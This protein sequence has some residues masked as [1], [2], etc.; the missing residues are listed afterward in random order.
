MTSVS[1]TIILPF[2]RYRKKE[3]YLT[4]RVV[5]ENVPQFVSMRTLVCFSFL[6]IF[7]FAVG[8]EF[9]TQLPNASRLTPGFDHVVDLNVS[10]D[11]ELRYVKDTAA[12]WIRV[13]VP[14]NTTCPSLYLI[15]TVDPVAGR[16]QNLTQNSPWSR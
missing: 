12:V 9:V 6:Y 3:A 14:R 11:L 8:Q 4:R 2:W 15:D 16:E 10:V 5:F 7:S 13:D 1:V